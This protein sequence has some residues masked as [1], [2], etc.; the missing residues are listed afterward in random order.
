LVTNL[1]FFHNV[2]ALVQALHTE[3]C[4]IFQ[5]V[6]VKR[7]VLLYKPLLVVSFDDAI[8]WNSLISK[9]SFSLPNT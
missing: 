3:H 7:D 1:S 4:E 6:M 9:T 2:T 8:G 5:A